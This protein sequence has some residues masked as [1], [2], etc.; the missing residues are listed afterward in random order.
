[1]AAPIDL[2]DATAVRAVFD[3]AADALRASP[4]R[5]GSRVVLPARGR[6]LATGDLHDNREHLRRIVHLAALDAS[7][8]HHVVLHELVHSEVLVNGLDLSHRM[9]A[10][11]AELVL[12]H[13]GQVHVLLGNHELAQLAGHR[14]SKGAGDNVQLFNDGLEFA[15]GDD[16]SVVAESVNRFIAALPLAAGSESGVLCAHSLPGSRTFDNFDPEVL[17]RDLADGDYMPRTGSAY[18]M[19]WGRGCD[20]AQVEVLAQRWGVKLFILGHEH[21]ENGLAI[22]GPR[23]LVLNS[24]HEFGTV[25]PLDLARAP[26]AEAA[27]QSA[28]RLR[29]VPLPEG[30]R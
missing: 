1:V 11:V 14:V 27:A 19:V 20:E 21:V 18:L 22:R 13:P 6:L 12:A 24:D 25:V 10:R 3:G 16:W 4:Q 23:I 17:D 15:F 8:D 26:A 5:R 29:S 30:D 28:I 2:Q 7:P 9:L